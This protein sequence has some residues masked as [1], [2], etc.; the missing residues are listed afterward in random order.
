MYSDVQFGS[1]FRQTFTTFVQTNFFVFFLLLQAYSRSFPS[2]SII[3]FHVEIKDS[4]H[5][6]DGLL[7]ELLLTDVLWRG[8]LA[9]LF[10]TF[11]LRVHSTFL[12]AFG[13]TRSCIPC[14]SRNVELCTLSVSVFPD[15]PL[16]IFISVGLRIYLFYC[17]QLHSLFRMSFS[18]SLHVSWASWS[19]LVYDPYGGKIYFTAAALSM[20]HTKPTTYFPIL[21]TQ[22]KMYPRWVGCEIQ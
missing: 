13:L 11:T 19:I 22:K 18:V 10:A 16:S 14:S 4:L 8:I 7:V 1:L 21:L 3:S 20:S 2:E 9:T 5:P 15:S 6:L 12:G 17:W